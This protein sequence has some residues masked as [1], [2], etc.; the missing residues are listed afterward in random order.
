MQTKFFLTVGFG[1][2]VVD[3]FLVLAS[4][5]TKMMKREYSG[6]LLP[7][8]SEGSEP[9][10]FLVLLIASWTGILAI[11]CIRSRKTSSDG[12]GTLWFVLILAIV[13]LAYLMPALWNKVMGGCDLKSDRIVTEPRFDSWKSSAK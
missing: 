13:W 10:R 8:G 5:A 6:Y 1:T 11:G 9:S 4:I 7:F 3:A 2:L 12:A